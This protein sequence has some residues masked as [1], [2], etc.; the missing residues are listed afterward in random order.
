MILRMKKNREKLQSLKAAI[1]SCKYWFPLGLNVL[2][3]Y[4]IFF[5]Q[6]LEK[7]VMFSFYAFGY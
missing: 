1:I 3:L 6:A 7:R 5:N 4:L 2:I